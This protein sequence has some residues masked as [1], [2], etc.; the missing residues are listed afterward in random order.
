MSE[1]HYDV[2]AHHLLPFDHV[3]FATSGLGY[4]AKRDAF[5]N[6]LVHS[7]QPD[8]QIERLRG[9]LGELQKH[10]D[11]RNNIAH[12]IWRD[13][14]RPGAIKPMRAITRGG[15]GEF[16]GH[17]NDER[18]YTALELADIADQLARNYNKFLDYLVEIG[19]AEIIEEKIDDSSSPT[20]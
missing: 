19:L 9:Y 5:K 10:N 2:E 20:T 16:I 14:A 15:K 12:A 17:D 7:G 8:A 4:A 11:L 6:L 13:G 1:T 18:D 3:V